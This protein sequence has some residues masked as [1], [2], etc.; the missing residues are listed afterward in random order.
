VG[1]TRDLRSRNENEVVI[2]RGLS[3]RYGRDHV[4]LDGI[5]L[6][7]RPGEVI[8]VVGANGSGKSTLLRIAAGCDRPTRGRVRGRPRAT[9]YLPDRFPAR[10]RLPAAS[11]LRHMAA[12][13]AIPAAE[14]SRQSSE[15]L[16]ELGFSGDMHTPMSRLSK[17][18]AQK[19]AL[20]Q[21]LCAPV[22][23]LVLDEPWSGLDT[24]AVP[25]LSARLIA[26]ANGGTAVLVSDHTGSA[27]RLPGAVVHRL[28][29]GALSEVDTTSTASANVDGVDTLV[30]VELDWSGE[31][32][33]LLE[34]CGS[35]VVLTADRGRITLLVP[36]YESDALLAEALRLGCSVRG[37]YQTQEGPQ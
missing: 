7:V 10:L 3:K 6:E 14:A 13:R 2:L 4:V 24:E 36:V 18:N 35:A 5:D 34:A 25:A 32:A 16:G 26:A 27:S 9:G 11:Y 8:V 22:E 21:A 30:H 37:V 23:L 20:T 33:A 17:G 29:G 12:L 19:V 1:S 28:A 31:P 15:L